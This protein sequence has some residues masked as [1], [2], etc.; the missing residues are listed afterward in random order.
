M[1]GRRAP[2]PRRIPLRLSGLPLLLVAGIVVMHAMTGAPSAGASSAP[3][4]ATADA[5]HAAMAGGAS[6]DVGDPGDRGPGP[7]RPAVHQMN[8]CVAMM[9]PAVVVPAPPA[10][11]QEIGPA[12]PPA[13]DGRAGRDRLLRGPAP[14][15][16]DLSMLCILR[17]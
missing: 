16:V 1:P 5:A 15:D 12:Q 13:P 9:A 8:P 7:P 4:A 2:R 10:T 14:P 6:S 17:T 3:A 11:A